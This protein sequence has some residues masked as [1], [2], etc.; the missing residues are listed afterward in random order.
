M[1]VEALAMYHVSCPKSPLSTGCD[2]GHFRGENILNSHFLP[3][4][5][6]AFLPTISPNFCLLFCQTNFAS[7]FT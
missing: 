5:S 2:M 3:E 6:P 7:Y 1:A 4:Q